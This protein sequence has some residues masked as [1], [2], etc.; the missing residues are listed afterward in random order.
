LPPPSDA[1]QDPSVDTLA[2]GATALGGNTTLAPVWQQQGFVCPLHAE[3]DSDAIAS[4]EATTRGDEEDASMT[5]RRTN[6][7]ARNETK[8]AIRIGSSNAGTVPTIS[9]VKLQALAGRG[10]GPASYESRQICHERF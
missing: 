6:R 8:L 1:P 7:A 10:A 5:L 9:E 4:A 2:I 3:T